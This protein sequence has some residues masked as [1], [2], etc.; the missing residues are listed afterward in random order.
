IEVA[1]LDD[2]NTERGKESGR[3]SAQLRARILFAGGMN[4][5]VRQELETRTKTTCVAPGNNN[6]KS[7]LCHSRKFFNATYRFLV[8]IDHLLRRFSVGHSGNVDGQHVAHVEAGL[9]RLQR[10]QRLDQ[11]AGACQ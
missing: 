7:G 9:R 6:P 2:R 3:N 8:E 5:T 10:E 4:M 11:S 1:A